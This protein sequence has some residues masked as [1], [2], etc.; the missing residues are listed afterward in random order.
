MPSGLHAVLLL[1]PE[2]SARNSPS[3]SCITWFGSS[4]VMTAGM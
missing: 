1:R 3:A 4:P 2:V